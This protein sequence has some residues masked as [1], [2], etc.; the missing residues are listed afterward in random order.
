MQPNEAAR[1]SFRAASAD[2]MPWIRACIRELRLDGENLHVE[3]FIVA[4]R[5]GQAV[6]FGRIKPYREV[7]ELG[8]VGVIEAERASGV[9]VQI[10]RELIRRFPSREVY[11][12]TDLID[13]FEKLGFR[14]LDDPPR[15]LAAKLQRIEGRIRSG[16]AAMVLVRED[17]A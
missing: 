17:D 10:V 16:V 9:G 7:S 1:L 8:C 15:E 6:G 3:Q 14:R 4:E 2:D 12:T 13:Y 5:E 11:I